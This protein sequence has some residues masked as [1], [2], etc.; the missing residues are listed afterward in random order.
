MPYANHLLPHSK[1]RARRNPHV[2]ERQEVSS[3]TEKAY[4]AVQKTENIDQEEKRQEVGP[5]AIRAVA[6]SAKNPITALKRYISSP[7]QSG[8]WA[9]TRDAVKPFRRMAE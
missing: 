1:G 4:K 3:D 6:P 5:T 9:P 8:V 7:L 2:E